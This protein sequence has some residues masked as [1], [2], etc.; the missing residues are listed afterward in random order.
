MIDYK[1]NA[2]FEADTWQ[3]LELNNFETK[4]DMINYF[5]ELIE[6]CI[7]QVKSG[8]MVIGIKINDKKWGDCVCTATMK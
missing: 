8:T 3:K 6:K 7:P 1:V 5:S 2:T 4:E